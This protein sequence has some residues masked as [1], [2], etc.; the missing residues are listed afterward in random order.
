MKREAR[1]LEEIEVGL[2][3]EGVYKCYGYDFRDYAPAS[4]RRRIQKSMAQEKAET[5]SALLD[6]VLVETGQALGA[7]VFFDVSEAELLRRLTGRRVCRRCQATYHV[8]SAPP[9]TDASASAVRAAARAPGRLTG[10]PR[11]RRSSSS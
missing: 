2:F 9:A 1:D 6:K 3:L 8:V 5:V 7:V 11:R 10:A 4:L